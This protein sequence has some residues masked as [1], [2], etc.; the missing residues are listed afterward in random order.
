MAR[1]AADLAAED[2]FVDLTPEDRAVAEQAWDD[3]NFE[4]SAA[5][6]AQGVEWAA[7]L[8][9][10]YRRGLILRDD[11][12][13]QLVIDRQ[14]L[15]HDRELADR[16]AIIA[17]QQ[18]TIDAQE[19]EIRNLR[20]QSSAIGA[21]LRNPKLH[22][23]ERV[24]GA[25]AIMEIGSRSSRG[26]TVD[27]WRPTID[28]PAH[29]ETPEDG[30][31]VGLA[32]ELG[33]S[34]N[35]IAKCLDAFAEPGGPLQKQTVQERDNHGRVVR[36]RIELRPSPTCSGGVPGMYWALARFDPDRPPK[37]EP[38]EPLVC[39]QHPEAKIRIRTVRTAVC[40]IDGEV[41]DEQATA[42]TAP[43]PSPTHVFCAPVAPISPSLPG[44]YVK[45]A[46]LVRRAREVC[47]V[48]GDELEG[49]DVGWP[50]CSACRV[51]VV[52]GTA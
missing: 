45:R 38:P 10:L 32:T 13:A 19:A 48:C 11:L 36:S 46:N 15:E 40:T 39:Q 44:T 7:Q 42:T 25:V 4:Q 3:A 34:R 29:P 6:F 30:A 33:L 41:L 26:H 22:T 23:A 17:R 35:T 16:D 51:A 1:I 50:A 47:E 43:R 12:P 2:L 31:R 20:A 37:S 9:R 18:A 52:A 8:D 14:Q 24:V 21:T 5:A 27:P 28:A 49:Q